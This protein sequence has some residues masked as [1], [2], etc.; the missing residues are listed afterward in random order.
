MSVVEGE[1]REEYVKV[2]ELAILKLGAT[3]AKHGF[4]EGQHLCV[5]RPTVLTGGR[6]T[7]LYSICSVA[8]LLCKHHE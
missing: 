3:L 4:V 2:K 7:R 5:P 1:L 8:I 6:G